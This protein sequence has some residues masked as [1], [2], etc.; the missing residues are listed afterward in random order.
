M[1]KDVSDSRRIINKHKAIKNTVFSSL[2]ISKLFW[3]K[4]N[5][6]E[7]ILPGKIMEMVD[8]Y[9]KT[10]EDSK[11]SRGLHWIPSEGSVELT[12]ERIGFDDITLVVTPIQATILTLFEDKGMLFLMK[13]KSQLKR[14]PQL[15]KLLFWIFE[16]Q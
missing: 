11:P 7:L 4:L 1:M 3:P 13:M 5:Q 10:F 6:S 9:Q 2:V 16:K 8:D 14:L 15:Q 12:V